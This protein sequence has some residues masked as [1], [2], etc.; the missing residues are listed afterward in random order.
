M[1]FWSPRRVCRSRGK[2]CVIITVDWTEVSAFWVESSAPGQAPP[3]PRPSRGRAWQRRRR[4]QPACLLFCFILS[5]VCSASGQEMRNPRLRD[6]VT[7]PGS[8]AGSTL[9]FCSKAHAFPAACVALCAPVLH[10]LPRRT[11]TRP[12]ETG[13]S[14]HIVE[15]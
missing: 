10:L 3:R 1:S 7:S 2:H 8:P 14:S 4:A 6:P 12:R 9:S 13:R 11:Q 5:R 15:I